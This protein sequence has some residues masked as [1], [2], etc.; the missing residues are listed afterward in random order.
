MRLFAVQSKVVFITG[1][2]IALFTFFLPI[3][4]SIRSVFLIGYLLLII[5]TPS[6]NRHL[7]SAVNTLWGWAGIALFFYVLMACF[8]SQAP[9]SLQI[10]VVEKYVKLLY[11]P[12]LAIGFI[13]PKLRV[14]CINSYLAAIVVTCVLSA[15]KSKGIFLV[16]DPGDIFYNH[17]IT[18]FMV[19]FASYLAGL[20]AFRFTGK[21]RVVYIILTLITSYQVLFINTGRT[22]YFIYFIL[23]SL[24]LLQQLS[25][26]KAAVGILLFC[27]VMALVY[28]ESAIMQTGAKNLASDIK[29][30]QQNKENT[31]LGYRIQFHNYAKSLWASHPLIGIGTGGFK[32]SFAN[33]NPIP[34]W[35]RVLTDP[36]SQYWMILAEQGLIGLGLLVFF[37]GSL[38]ITAFKLQETR[39]ILL[40]ILIAFGIGS[41]SDTI[42][43]FSTAGFILILMSSLSLGELLEKHASKRAKEEELVINLLAPQ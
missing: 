34:S 31:S 4:A 42:L 21:S 20:F 10:T 23:M 38:L 17:I 35:G 19:A 3:S 28:H 26:K 29:F 13:H 7:F 37:L 1:I 41:L 2:L 25:F 32:Y 39:P 12:I 11:S 8:W 15:L 18:G 40:G 22:G 9:Y 27:G 33:D 24:L 14:V 43:C 30:L 36:H 6:Y 5:L 16:G